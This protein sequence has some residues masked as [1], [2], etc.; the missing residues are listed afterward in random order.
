MKNNTPNDLKRLKAESPRTPQDAGAE[1]LRVFVCG[2]PGAGKTTLAEKL[3]E[4]GQQIE[5]T[6]QTASLEMR[7]AGLMGSG[8]LGALDEAC[9]TFVTS[10][11]VF[12]IRDAPGRA[13]DT[14]ML[15]AAASMSDV[16]LIVVDA[17]DG[18]DH[19][20]H[21][22]ALI[23][24]MVGPRR[25]V[26]AVNKLDAADHAEARFNEVRG[27]FKEMARLL[28]LEAGAAIPIVA[29]TGGNV[30][31][32]GDELS[33]YRGPTLLEQ[34]EAIQMSASAAE[35][36]FR[37]VV[38]NAA[39]Q[40]S[41]GAELAGVIGSG[42]VRR[43]DEIIVLP[44]SASARILGLAA[45]DGEVD[46]AGAGDAV[47]LGLSNPVETAIG[48]VVAA[49]DAEPSV[50]DQVAVHLIWLDREPL[51][52]GRVY[53]IAV[54]LQTATATVSTL[55]HKVDADT[56]EHQAA[57]TLESGDVGYGNLSISRPVVFDAYAQNPDLGAFVLF[58]QITNAAV[59]MGIFDFGLWRATNVQWQALEVEKG[60][61]ADL[62][63]QRPCV[64]WFTGLSGA[65]K[66]TI[67]SLLEKRL[68]AMGR[69]TYV[70][71]GD[72][73][74]H[75]LNKDLGFTDAD[76]V[77]NIRRVAET[78]KLFVDAGLIVMVSFISP[79]RMERR[80]ARDLLSRDEFVEVFVDASI[81]VCEQRDPKGL[82]KKA[83]AGEI[84]N[85]TG[86]DSAY[87]LPENADIT[88][89]A[90]EMSPDELVEQMMREL[91]RRDLI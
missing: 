3:A 63:G 57:A 22:Q 31:R 23:S 43:G 45:S 42:R 39:R 46:E 41:S 29:E 37:M 91:K 61:R 20:A 76:R 32:P 34:L 35:R 6:T 52:P 1:P 10:N 59:A 64:L 71:D 80:M 33:W 87:E 30:A 89:A 27:Q 5:R 19:R 9:K 48:D 26:L 75:G 51:L 84:R 55:K 11:G 13:S 72:N 69:H 2:P 79:F 70:L 86:I 66:S 8:A 68:H 62:K 16:A 44:E 12:T 54:G 78:A 15:A 40:E 58:D 82:Y 50:S 90:S 73:V 77:E 56:L 74:R 36:P 53:A 24:S 88:L 81:E 85:F 4:A 17:G 7:F 60:A 28:A 18:L 49:V 38:Q 83:R 67:A 47:T 21:Y 65:G 25:V 14:A